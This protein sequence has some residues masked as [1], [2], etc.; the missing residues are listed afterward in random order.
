MENSDSACVGYQTSAKTYSRRKVVVESESQRPVEEP[1]IMADN[2]GRATLSSDPPIDPLVRLRRLP[3]QFPQNL[4]A[5]VVPPNLTQFYDTKDEDTSRH[6]KRY[7]ERLASSLITDPCYCL[8]WF[9]TTL[10]G[11]A[12]E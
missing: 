1:T 6:M 8:M 5:M 12:Y 11:E 7:I 9:P 4:A 3:I 10:E 2:G